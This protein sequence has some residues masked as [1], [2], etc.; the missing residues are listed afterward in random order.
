MKAFAELYTALD[1]TNKTNEKISILAEYFKSTPPEDAIWAIAFL[2]GRRPKRIINS[3]KL[4]TW[5]MHESGLPGWLFAESYDAVGDLGETITLLLKKTD[6]V[7]MRPLHWWIEERMLKLAKKE[8]DE[9]R[10]DIIDSWNTMSKEQR[11]VWNK[12][13]TGSFRVGVS[14]KLIVKG[15][16]KASGIDENVI[17]HRLMGSWQPTMEFYNSLMAADTQDADISKPY[18]FYLAYQLDDPPSTLGDIN[19]WTAEWKWDGIRSQI[20]KRSGEVF[21][22]SRGEDLLTDRFPELTETASY[23]EEGTVLDG[24]ILAWWDNMPMNFGELQKRIGRKNLTKKI[25]DDVP[26]MFQAFDI[27]EYEG[28]DIREEPL[29]ERKAKLEK[30][31]RNLYRNKKA[32]DTLTLI[33]EDAQLA[34]IMDG[35]I[36]ASVSVQAATWEELYEIRE[37]SRKRGVEGF[38]I[39]KNDSP[40]GVGRRRGGWWKWKIDPY[41]VDAVLIYAQRGHGRRASLY[42]DYT[43]G[44]WDNG[45]LVPFA[46]AYSGLTDEEIRKVDSFVRRNTLEKFGPVRTVK[47]ELVFE[48]AFE[49]IQ[50][51]TRHKSGIA[52]RF[53]RIAKWRTDK[54]IED[55]DSLDDVKKLLRA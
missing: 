24:E 49:G 32:G 46:K 51:S 43:F 2:T 4:W 55:A 18:P 12:L 21:I 20:I 10:A 27:L 52:V 40:Y 31:V 47:P 48:L 16:A 34:D 7:D 33:E 15:I 14:A 25:M 53:P 1:E 38:V 41:A 3:T 37:E 45:N 54:K 28:R 17:S 26:I 23:L 42:T 11:F 6:K 36:A 8:E 30:A 9:Q 50:E 19:E 39:K 44:V 29:A 35:N 22:W 5:A 13:L